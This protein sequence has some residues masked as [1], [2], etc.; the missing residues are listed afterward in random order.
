M[1]VGFSGEFGF[2]AVS[3]RELSAKVR[4]RASASSRGEM[5]VTARHATAL[6]RR[7][8]RLGRRGKAAFQA[9]GRAETLRR[10]CTQGSPSPS[11][12]D[13]LAVPVQA[14]VGDGHR[15]PLHPGPAQGGQVG[16]LVRSHRADDH[17]RVPGFHLQRRPA[18]QH[19]LPHPRRVG[20]PAHH[21][22]AVM[23]DVGLAHLQDCW[24]RSVVPRLAGHG[25]AQ[26]LHVSRGARRRGGA[27]ATVSQREGL[28]GARRRR[29]RR[30]LPAQ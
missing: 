2:H 23:G 1:H 4:G 3:P 20:K 9:L 8:W 29:P 13:P 5:C 25:R 11:I 18:H 14:G 26:G 30:Q 28:F 21:P 10:W 7:R 15:H 12:P 6:G 16:A 27:A 17:A 24:G 19:H 22:G